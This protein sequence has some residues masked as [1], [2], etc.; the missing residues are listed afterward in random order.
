MGLDMNFY[1]K[2]F[3][4]V[5]HNFHTRDRELFEY[6]TNFVCYG[7][8]EYSQYVRLNKRQI[9]KVIKYMS[10]NNKYGNYNNTIAQLNTCKENNIAIYINADW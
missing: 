2:D 1:K 8:N 3:V 6:I 7:D 5:D 10:K 4:E 9:N